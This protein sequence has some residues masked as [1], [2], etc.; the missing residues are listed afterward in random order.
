MTL[1]W[2]DQK[3]KDERFEK[4][5]KKDISDGP[6]K[7]R[8]CTDVWCLCVYLILM[9]GFV[10]VTFAGVQD[11]N[12]SK[13]YSPRDFKGDYC[14]VE[15][16]WMSEKDLSHHPKLLYTMNVSKALDNIAKQFV[17][18]TFASDLLSTLMTASDYSEY[19]CACCIDPCSDCTE[20][21]GLFDLTSE[22]AV[23][24]TIPG[25]MAELTSVAAATSLFST[26]GANGG[27]FN[28]IWNEFSQ[29]FWGVC[30]TTCYISNNSS[31]RTYLWA[32]SPDM[33]WKASW[34]LLASDT[35][36]VPS[37]I[38]D[39]MTDSFTF[40]SF[41]W[42]DC[43][44]EPRYCVPFPGAT[45]SDAPGTDY[46][47]PEVTGDVAD[48]LGDALDGIG[49]TDLT[50][51]ATETFGS[52]VG[53]MWESWDV[54][55]LVC[56]YAFIFGLVFLLLLRFFVGVCVW[57]ALLF[58]IVLFGVGGCVAYVRSI[59]CSGESLTGS[60]TSTAYAAGN[61]AVIL[62]TSSNSASESISGNGMDYVGAQTMTWSGRTCQHWDSTT[63]HAHEY[64]PNDYPW[65]DLSSNYCRN[66]N[67][68]SVTIWCFTTDTEKRWDS[69]SP[70]GTI[71]KE[72]VNGYEV[73]D[74]GSREAL[75]IL[76][77]IIWGLAGLWI[78]VVMCLF[79]QIR[80]A[81]AINKVAAMF[82]YHTPSVLFVP[83]VQGL[84]GI[85]WCFIWGLC[86][87]FLLSQVPDSY[88]PT[89]A[90]ASYAEA[91]G[92]DD[93]A[94]RCTDQWPTGMVWKYNGDDTLMNDTCSGNLG[95]TAGIVPRCWR[96][97]PP[98]YVFDARFVFSFFCYL[99]NN[100]FLI[101]LGQC[102][103]A[104]ACGVWFFASRGE[105][106]KQKSVRTGAYNC[107]RYHA[108]SL[109]FGAFIIAVVQLARAIMKYMEKNAQA[110]RNKIMQLVFRALG[111]L[112]WCFEKCLKFLN[113]NAYIQIAL[114]G[115]N[116]CVSAKNAFFLILRNSF[117]FGVLAMLGSVIH[118]IGFV[119][120]TLL[121]ASCGYLTLYLIYEHINPIIP[122]IVYVGVGW[123]MSKLYM[124]VFGL[125]VDSMLQCFI[126]TEE[127][128][129][130]TG[131]VPGPLRSLAPKKSSETSAVSSDVK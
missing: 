119:F 48:V 114:L 58:V 57:S 75:R 6:I 56:I 66:P 61:T 15:S 94:G 112:I 118:F 83:I 90:Y 60:T 40:T 122:V 19:R 115:T 71:A 24:G 5:G 89:E 105:K 65:A 107:L 3:E 121:T 23:L 67:G 102:I 29:Y 64:D 108:G 125:A 100:A 123:V 11:G 109:A 110:Q 1:A 20:S 80:L 116:F 4:G 99:W 51:S 103:V 43:P 34:D 47:Q 39:M 22:S 32:P 91:M 95:D 50:D 21:L 31:E 37:A 59:Q 2:A 26:T 127:M 53:D 54:L 28:N 17:C 77:Y 27:D 124:N 12:P 81:V 84:V 85:C 96:C 13:L 38:H 98:R 101:A 120:I 55:L 104:G 113:K 14:S 106:S 88:T 74:S 49:V 76:A 129:G 72:C 30:S 8:G 93:V 68:T 33:F 87:S 42:N 92:T 117:R 79:K 52:M 44:Y 25:K 97:A 41:S 46:C 9:V 16:Q 78:L 62:T 18:S 10:I 86:A 130:D 7:D 111:C 73:S 35:S 70:I 131:F 82:V 63:P 128:G 126:A 36:V 45:F 69:C